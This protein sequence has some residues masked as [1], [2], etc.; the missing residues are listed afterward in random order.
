M[1]EILLLLEVMFIKFLIND[2]TDI[3]MLYKSNI[4]KSLW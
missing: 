4:E 2:I 3:Q 1:N